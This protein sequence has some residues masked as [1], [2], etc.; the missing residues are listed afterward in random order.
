LALA[1]FDL[2]APVA[3]GK[4]PAGLWHPI[5][6]LSLSTDTPCYGDNSKDDYSGD[7]GIGPPVCWLSVPT[8]GRRPDLLGVRD[9]ATSTH[10]E[11]RKWM[12]ARVDS[13][14]QELPKKFASCF[15]L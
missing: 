12:S 6:M 9:L 5:A 4:E 1:F 3:T 15:N 7:S 2:L 10:I 14:E 13:V 8:S 11:E